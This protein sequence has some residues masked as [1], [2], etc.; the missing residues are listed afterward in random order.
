MNGAYIDI[1]NP[2]EV[3]QELNTRQQH[4]HIIKDRI[5]PAQQAFIK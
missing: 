3:L 4:T 2:F 1:Y 5:N